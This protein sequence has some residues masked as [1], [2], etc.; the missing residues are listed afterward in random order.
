MCAVPSAPRGD[1]R[2]VA[3]RQ[4]CSTPAGACATRH[5]VNAGYALARMVDANELRFV[6]LGDLSLLS[7]RMGAEAA[8]RP[9]ADW[10]RANG[11]LVDP[12]LWRSSPRSAMTLYDLRSD[13]GLITAA[14][15][16][17]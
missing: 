11:K 7:R 8:S 6:M 16:R 1:V 5:T 12:A 2:V 13:V 17:P 3:L 9:I 4:L 15:P 10:V 14:G